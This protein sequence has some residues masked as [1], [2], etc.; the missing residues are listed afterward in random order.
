MALTIQQESACRKL[1]RDLLSA[2]IWRKF[3]IFCAGAFFISGA[4]SLVLRVLHVEGTLVAF[5]VLAGLLFALEMACFRGKSQLPDRAQLLACVDK[6]AAHRGMLLFSDE[7]DSEQWN[8]DNGFVRSLKVKAKSG[9]HFLRFVLSAFFVIA[10][11]LVPIRKDV[12]KVASPLNIGT[13]KEK[14]LEKIEFM[15][16]EKVIDADSAEELKRQLNELESAAE[17]ETPGSTWEGLDHLNDRLSRK[18]EKVAEKLVEQA[19][20]L[21]LSTAV[22]RELLQ[23]K[24][25]AAKAEFNESAA[26]IADIL[27]QLAENCPQIDPELASAL[28]QYAKNGKVNREQLKKLLAGGEKTRKLLKQ[29]LEKMRKRGMCNMGGGSQAGTDAQVMELTEE[30]IKKLLKMLDKTGNSSGGACQA[31]NSFILNLPGLPG[32]AGV[33]RGRGDASMTWRK[34]QLDENVKWKELEIPQP[35]AV[36][37]KKSQV[38]GISWGVEKA[39]P[40]AKVSTGHLS[41]TAVSGSDAYRHMLLPRHRRSVNRYFNSAK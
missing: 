4:L 33:S 23:T 32:Q 28:K 21:A 5:P 14:L 18:S 36:S 24:Q 27:K 3:L 20:E 31:L 30:N 40:S 2:L 11:F 1:R 16:R 10:V 13:E 19:E 15:E 29:L 35:K 17:G 12:L 6:L 9:T 7:F 25:A 38:V 41:E 22:A 39:D 8:F 26:A 37:L 34:R